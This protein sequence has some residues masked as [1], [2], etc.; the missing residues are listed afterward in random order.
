MIYIKECPAGSCHSD[1]WIEGVNSLNK[2]D[3]TTQCYLA[4]YVSAAFEELIHR[5]KSVVAATPPRR[6]GAGSPLHMSYSTEGI[7][8]KK[9]PGFENI[10]IRKPSTPSAK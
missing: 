7:A 6:D 3:S 4:L 10:E 8:D 1:W 2:K 9:S 5:S